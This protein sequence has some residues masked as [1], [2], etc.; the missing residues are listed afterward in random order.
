[1]IEQ[2]QIPNDF[3]AEQA[4]LGTVIYD[5]D[6]FIS[7]RSIIQN[8]EYFYYSAH[9]HIYRAMIELS[10]E[11]VKIDEFSLGDKL[12]GHNQLKNVGGYVY[13]STLVEASV[14]VCYSE[15]WAKIIAEKAYLRKL[16]TISA[17]ATNKVKNFNGSAN[18][19]VDALIHD[20]ID[21]R[22][23]LTTNAKAVSVF[24]CM[25][26]ITR[27]IELVQSGKME[28]GLRSG[29]RDY[30]LMM[31]GG[32]QREDLI[33]I[34]ARPSIGKTSLGVCLSYA[35][36]F[37]AKKGLIMSIESSKESIIRD[38]LLPAA[39]SANSHDVRA[40]K[41][42]QEQ[43]D[44]LHSFCNDEILKNLKICDSSAVTI[45]D[46]YSLVS[47]EK[48]TAGIDFV[49]ID[50]IQLMT[51]THYTGNRNNDLG[52][53]ARG[54]KRIC[55]DFNIP[56]I[57]LSQLNEKEKLRDSG[58]LEQV[59]DVIIIL[60]KDEALPNIIN[61]DFR[62]NRNGRRGKIPLEFIPEFTKFLPVNQ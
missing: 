16:L 21:L 23:A 62:K 50:F 4:I 32:A 25:P 2:T 1:M 37:N 34:G 31:G 29:Y 33:F 58:E 13:F 30:D 15:K 3:E 28:S 45:E 26:T 17:N 35:M 52:E 44:R 24:D 19:I 42:T 27:N 47:I 55:K 9:Q 54:L 18:E 57:V 48:K 56:V 46:V 59:A 39:I 7:I 49:L 61:C 40:G 22:R 41:L 12:K 5:N 8:P 10:E 53:I 43:W 36:I 60:Q 38:R 6:S 20:L 51:P 11:N 14:D